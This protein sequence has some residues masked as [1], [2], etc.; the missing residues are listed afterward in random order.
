MTP[1]CLGGR[2]ISESQTPRGVPIPQVSR[3]LARPQPT[4]AGVLV[5]LAVLTAPRGAR[6]WQNLD[7]EAMLGRPGVKLVA[8]DFY[9][10]WCKPCNEAIPKWRRL[11]AKYQDRGLRLIVVTVRSEGACADPGWTPDQ[12]VCDEDGRVQDR[13]GVR[14]L[15]QAFLWSWQ[16]HLLAGHATV[17]QVEE[18][19]A[20]YFRSAP[21]ILVDKPVARGGKRLKGAGDLRSMVRTELRRAAKF[22]LVASRKERKRLKKELRRSYELDVREEGRCAVGEAVPANSLLRVV[23]GRKEGGRGGRRLWL[24]LVSLESGCLVASASQQ[25]PR[26]GREAAVAEGVVKLVQPLV[27][28]LELPAG[29]RQGGSGEA[30]G[31]QPIQAGKGGVLL[32]STPVGAEVWVDDASVGRTCPGGLAISLDPGEHRLRFQL[33]GHREKTLRVRATKGEQADVNVALLPLS[34]AGRGGLDASGQPG[35]LSVRSSPQRATVLL[36]GQDAGE[37]TNVNLTLPPGRYVV[38]LSKPLYLPSAEKVVDVRSGEVVLVRETLTPDFGELR[39]TS[40]PS[41]AEVLVNGEPAGTT[42]LHRPQQQAG[43]LQ[44]TVRFPLHLEHTEQVRLEAGGKV[45]LSPRLVSAYGRLEVVSEPSGAELLLDGTA[46]GRTPLTL[47]R[48]PLGE[49]RLLLRL[50]LH[51]TVEEAVEVGAGATRTLRFELAANYGILLVHPPDVA[52]QVY[53]DGERLGPPGRFELEAGPRVVE[54]RPEEP[55]HHAYEQAV[56]IE[57][58]ETAELTPELTPR[59]GGLLI[60]TEPAGAR[61]LVDGAPQASEPVRL[62]DLLIGRHELRAEE[63]GFVPERREV[64]VE[65]GRMKTVLLR[66]RP[67]GSLRVASTP[68]GARVLVDDRLR[69][70]TP[71]DLA[72]IE[73]GP[74]E[75]RCELE[76]YLTHAEEV[77]ARVGEG[78]EVACRL[79]PRDLVAE[80]RTSKLWWGGSSLAVGLAAGVAAAYAFG[81]AVGKADEA[82]RLYAEYLAARE[83]A[84]AGTRRAETEVTISSQRLHVALGA[85]AAGLAAAL[86]GFSAY[87]LV[88]LPAPEGGA[89]GGLPGPSGHPAEATG[90]RP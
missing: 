74:H 81:A 2:I 82:D 80:E 85:A 34:E 54:V 6:A 19:I 48:V 66:L 26:S 22:D 65:E 63:E 67:K 90:G 89:G 23:V 73:S 17:E 45:A 15:P 13:W 78:A 58:G 77:E 31:R 87:E 49:H 68:P 42:P 32:R 3:L 51:E 8:V 83:P 35:V 16:G 59:L 24:E 62:E 72:G 56:Q 4:L 36:D 88:T 27:R 84:V 33:A 21:R 39:V 30:G 40:T 7:V 11:Q 38:R 57:R 55:S 69:G 9:A 76:G 46:R 20:E 14:T 52:A 25:L 29:V 44:I 28:E 18:K 71:L 47:D 50:P 86:L 60:T 79:V 41:G 75:V 5:V 53:V 1:R 43:P 70:T 12:V 61:V 10:T 64:E 37:T